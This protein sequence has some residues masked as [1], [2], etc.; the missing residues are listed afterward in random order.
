[1][2]TVVNQFDGLLDQCWVYWKTSIS[3]TT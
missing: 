3:I 2:Y 1:M